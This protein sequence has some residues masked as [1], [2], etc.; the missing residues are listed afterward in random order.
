M[1]DMI[2]VIN[3]GSFISYKMLFMA[4]CQGVQTI[5]KEKAKA[6]LAETLDSKKV[7]FPRTF[8]SYF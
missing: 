7:S 4:C 5:D 8:A 6:V 3:L 1:F 2:S